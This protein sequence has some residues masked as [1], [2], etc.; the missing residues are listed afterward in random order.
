MRRKIRKTNSPKLCKCKEKMSEIE[1]NEIV[2]LKGSAELAH[3]TAMG[4]YVAIVEG[5]AL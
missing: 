4:G 5:L 1:Q 3:G 2:R